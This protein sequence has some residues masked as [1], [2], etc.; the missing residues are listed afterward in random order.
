MTRNKK[1]FPFFLWHRR[2]GLIA[3]IL[4]LIL[5]FTGI[6]LNHTES[7]QLDEQ[8]VESDLLLNWYGLNPEN[9]PVSYQVSDSIISLWDGQ[10]FLNEK[11]ISDSKQMLRGA[12]FH[13]NMIVIALD[14][15]IQLFDSNG[16]LI[17]EIDINMGKITH[18]GSDNKFVYL[19]NDRQMIFISDGQIL[20]WTQINQTTV[21]WISQITANDTLLT[22][23]KKSYR[24]QGLTLERV[25]LDLHSGRLFNQNWGVYLMDASAI[26]MIWLGLSGTWIWFSRKNKMKTKRH[27]QKH[28]MRTSE[29]KLDQ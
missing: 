25:I 13:D 2:L 19:K 23:M 28:H 10:L 17:E 1:K 8:T 27:Y 24:G 18:I 4:M 22:A 29:A 5:C 12:V 16:E 7:L 6:A 20:N 9:K 21:H 14:D 26:I 11:I 3:L 15:S